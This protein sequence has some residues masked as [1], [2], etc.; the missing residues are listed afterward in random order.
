M[1]AEISLSWRFPIPA[2]KAPLP[3]LRFKA[4]LAVL[5]RMGL[6]HNPPWE[7]SRAEEG[8][9]GTYWSYKKPGEGTLDTGME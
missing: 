1:E 2:A 4:L 5:G 6:C 8:G 3:G 9:L 7:E